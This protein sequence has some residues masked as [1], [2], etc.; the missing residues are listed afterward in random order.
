[1][2]STIEFRSLRARSPKTRM[3]LPRQRGDRCLAQSTTPP[4][5]LRTWAN[6]ALAPSPPLF[7]PDEIPSWSGT[8]EAKVLTTINQIAMEV[9]EV[10]LT[11]A[12]IMSGLLGAWQA[13]QLLTCTFSAPAAPASKM[14][15]THAAVRTWCHSYEPMDFGFMRMRKVLSVLPF[16]I[17]PRS[18][19]QSWWPRNR[20]GSC[21][22]PTAVELS[23]TC[24]RF[25]QTLDPTLF[26]DPM[27]K[28][29][30]WNNCFWRR[31][32]NSEFGYFADQC[33]HSASTPEHN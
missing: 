20:S 27:R 33:L 10:V 9:V 22:I 4:L 23:A 19:S 11:C 13:Y 18:P 24:C 6:K 32:E 16:G 8:T 28:F 7:D 14:C 31:R 29:A 3:V 5:S 17:R 2:I 21:H 12:S 30:M 25:F 15:R 26:L 1:M